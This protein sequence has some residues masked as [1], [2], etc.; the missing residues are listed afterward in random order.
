LEKAIE[1]RKNCRLHLPFWNVTRVGMVK[2]KEVPK[3]YVS[4]PST[5]CKSLTNF[6]TQ[7]RT[8]YTS[9]W[10]GLFALTT[11]VVTCTSCKDSCKESGSNKTLLS[12]NGFLIYFFALLLIN[13]DIVDK[14][15]EIIVMIYFVTKFHHAVVFIFCIYAEIQ[16]HHNRLFH[17]YIAHNVAPSTPRHERDYSH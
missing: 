15:R 10:T 1:E 17:N 13:I 6:I 2:Y 16:N 5:C 3:I 7:C 4:G 12:L 9:T 14:F 8:K 11:L